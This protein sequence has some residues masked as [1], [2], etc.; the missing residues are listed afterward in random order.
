MLT[1]GYLGKFSVS[2]TSDANWNDDAF[3]ALVLDENV[4]EFVHDL[5][6]E[7]KSGNSRAFDDI[8]RDKG[9][10]LVGLLA[11]SPGVGKV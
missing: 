5:V 4:K 11:G 2:Q 1:D 6:T 3:K 8:V 10:G 7:H 9:K